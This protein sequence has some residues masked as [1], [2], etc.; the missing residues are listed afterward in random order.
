LAAVVAVVVVICHAVATEALADPLF[1]P[2]ALAEAEGLVAEAAE[3]EVSAALEAE[4]LAA[5]VLA[6]IGKDVPLNF[7]CFYY[8]PYL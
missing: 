5:G 6:A 8:L 3:V 1:S 7:G 4:A 2:A